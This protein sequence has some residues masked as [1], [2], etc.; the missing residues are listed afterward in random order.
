MAGVTGDRQSKSDMSK[1]GRMRLRCL[2][3]APRR[4]WTSTFQVWWV[5]AIVVAPKAA[6][7]A[8]LMGNFSY[9]PSVHHHVLAGLAD[10]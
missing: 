4:S 9:S 7:A 2:N 10:G 8:S 5:I 6:L 1:V 3:P